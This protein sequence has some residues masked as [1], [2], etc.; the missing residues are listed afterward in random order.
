MLDDVPRIAE[1][2][3]ASLLEIFPR[4]YDAR[5]DRERRWSTSPSSTSSSSRTARTSCTSAAGEI[6]ACGGWSRR[7]KLFAGEG[8]AEGD[9]RLLDPRTEPARVRDDVR[10]QRLDAAR[11]R[12][13]DPACPAS[14]AAR[15][16]GFTRLVLGA[17]LPGVPLY[18][19]VR[20]SCGAAASSVVT[21]DGVALA[22]V[23]MEREIS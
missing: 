16:E 19:G 18:C 20:V 8:D 7:H 3:R 1:L 14:D 23:A 9:D 11:A 22:G 21:P 5:A 12:A 2:M 6:V 4:Y 13:R 17:T 15:A 10:A